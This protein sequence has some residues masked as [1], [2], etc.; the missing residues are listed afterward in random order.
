MSYLKFDK[1]LMI[2]LEQSLLKEILRTN[3][4]GA[5]S[6]STIVDCNTRKQQGLLVI[7]LPE[8][9]GGNHVLMSTL[10]ATVIQ[11]GAEFN[12]GLHK[13]PGDNFSPK[14]HKYIREYECDYNPK[15]TYRVGGV[16]LTKETI[17]V[18]HENRLL[19]KYSLIDAHSPTT[20]RFKPFLAFRNTM[21]LC[22]ENSVINKEC[23]PVENGVKACLYQ[24]YPELFMQ[25]SRKNKFITEPDWYRNIEYMKDQE[26]MYD[27]QED[28]FVPGYFE[29]NI[30]KGESIIF[31][32]G[33][34]PLSPR[35]MSGLFEKETSLRTPR[36]SFTNC[37][38]NAAYQFYNKHE[39]GQ[40]YIIAGYPWFN[41][42]ARDMFISLPGLTISAKDPG[43]FDAIMDTGLKAIENFIEK[44]PLGCAISAMD[45]PDVLLWAVWSVQE[46]AKY[47]GLNKCF[48][49]YGK[50]VFDIIEFIRK[51]KHDNLF[52]HENG[53]LYTN[54][55]EKP[56]SWINSMIN[57][58]PITP[59]S[60]YLV[61]FNALWYNTLLFGVELSEFSEKKYHLNSYK[62]LADK[63]KT[64][65]IEVF[66]NQHGYL[67]DYVDNNNPDWSVRPNMIFAASL[68]YSPLN[69]VQKKKIVDLVTKELLTP[70]GLRSL[71]PKSTGYLP[72]YEGNADQRALTCH[73]GPSYP[74]LIGPY[75]DAYLKIYK[76]SGLNFAQ[77]V[78]YGFEE[79]LNDRGIGTISEFFDGNPP[80]RARGGV[81]FAMNVAEILRIHRKMKNIMNLNQEQ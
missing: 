44:K 16:I 52:L 63:T 67:Y 54:G 42:R 32:A 31:S 62:K 55:H 23:I 40:R 46:Y 49:K 57:G 66:L 1:N 64:S 61:E 65:F 78:I 7:P 73:Q 79:E 50:V 8:L 71:S 37:L 28:L 81:S 34:S 43:L 19:V 18:S 27:Y 35:K 68:E 60:G 5:Y 9:D 24:K 29:V 11:R 26:Q 75:L 14:G 30:A 77:K 69:A 45:D 22:R 33:T 51:Q 4:S 21:S 3:K 2:N 15:T 13:Y 70:K 58:K 39:D 74:W 80:Y 48:D 53:L 72:N 59:R 41:Y 20:L 47:N 25:L 12:L 56:V 36:S 76:N 6:Y 10:D 17:F 38:K